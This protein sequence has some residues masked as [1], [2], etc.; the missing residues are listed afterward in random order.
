MYYGLTVNLPTWPP[1]LGLLWQESLWSHGLVVELV[2]ACDPAAHP[3]GRLEFR[4]MVE[5]GS[6]PAAGRYAAWPIQAG[7]DASFQRLSPEDHAMLSTE[8]PAYVRALHRRCPLEAHFSTDR[9]RTVADHRLQC[10]AAAALTVAG[11]GIMQDSRSGDF[12]VGT[13]AWRHAARAADRY[14]AMASSPSD[15]FLE[16]CQVASPENRRVEEALLT[17]ELMRLAEFPD[18]DRPRS[19]AI[20]LGLRPGVAAPPAMRDH[21]AE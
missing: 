14:E 13:E 20:A 9:G 2:A 7:F 1:D 12:L 4:L 11:G 8:C 16:P 15:W 5:P 18:D 6:F 3:E 21:A 17:S 19:L 10:F